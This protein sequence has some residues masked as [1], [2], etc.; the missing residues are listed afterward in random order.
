[1]AE[2]SKFLKGEVESKDEHI[3][4]AN[5]DWLINET[6]MVKVLEGN[7]KNKTSSPKPKQPNNKFNQFP[8][9]TYTDQDYANLE[10]ELINKS[11]QNGDYD[12]TE[13]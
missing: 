10:K 11:S 9:R 6:N 3:W 12:G 7:Y 13:T 4:K 1:M 5:F 2:E 8:Q